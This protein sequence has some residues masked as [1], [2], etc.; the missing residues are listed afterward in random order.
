MKSKNK[1]LAIDACESTVHYTLQV[2]KKFL[3]TFYKPWAKALKIEVGIRV[4][5][6]TYK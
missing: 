2:D 5:S 3:L 4:D 6:G 1:I